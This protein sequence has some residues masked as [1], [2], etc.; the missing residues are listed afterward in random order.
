MF[1]GPKPVVK[2][3]VASVTGFICCLEPG[4]QK[5]SF[6]RIGCNKPFKNLQGM[7]TKNDRGP[8]NDILLMAHFPV[9]AIIATD[10]N[11]SISG[12]RGKLRDGAKPMSL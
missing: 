3:N 12:G 8:P 2:I 10:T 4:A 1:E 11:L 7:S 9:L 6:K 5:Y